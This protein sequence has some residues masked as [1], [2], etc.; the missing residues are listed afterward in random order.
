MVNCE[1][2]AP[3]APLFFLAFSMM[4]S[5]H[6]LERHRMTHLDGRAERARS[7]WRDRLRN[8]E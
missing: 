2:G 8:P 5:C 1:G 6:S 4:R 3:V 7:G